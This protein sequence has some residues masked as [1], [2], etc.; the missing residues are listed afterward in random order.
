V[1]SRSHL[2]RTILSALFACIIAIS[3]SGGKAVTDNPLVPEQEHNSNNGATLEIS[4]D[5]TT[6]S[7]DY[8]YS[9]SNHYLWSYHLIYI[10]PTSPD[11]IDY[12][13][14]PV[15]NVEGHW[16]VLKFLEQGPCAN[17]IKIT[18]ASSTGNGTLNLD[19]TL[20]HPF[21]D[22]T[23][24]GFDVKG[25]LMWKGSYTFT[26]SGLSASDRYAGDGAVVDAE[27]FTS[28]YN[29]GTAG[30]GPGGLQGYFAGK[31]AVGTPDADLNGYK[32]F[33]SPGGTNTRNA[34]YAG[35][36]TTITYEVDLPDSAFVVGYA[37]DANWLPPTTI[38]VTNPIT[39]FPPE[40]NQPEPWKIETSLE[41]I[42]EGFTQ[43]GGA[44]KLIIDVY[45]WQGK[46]SHKYPEIE[47]P[48]LFDGVKFVQL[49]QDN[50]GWAR[51]EK[52]IYND[53][54]AE[55]G[56]VMLL[57]TVEDYANAGSPEYLN[58]TTYQVVDV[59]IGEHI[60]IP[61]IAKIQGTPGLY[62]CESGSFKNKGS[63][64]PDSNI[65]KYEWDWDNNGTWDEE[66]ASVFHSWPTP[67][68]NFIQFRVTTDDGQTDTLDEPFQ[69]IA[70]NSLPWS[71]PEADATTIT[72]GTT[73]HF[74][75]LKSTD[76]DCDGQ[77]ITL[78][79]WDFQGDGT[80]DA[81]GPEVEYTYNDPGFYPVDLRVRDN[82]G[83]FSPSGVPGQITVSISVI[84]YWSRVWG[85]TGVDETG[86]MVYDGSTYV[87]TAGQFSGTVDFDPTGGVM[88]LTASD[89]WD[90]YVCKYDKDGNL[91]WVVSYGGTN[92]DIAKRMEL[93]GSGDLHIVGSFLGNCDFDPG[94]GDETRISNGDYDGYHLVLDSSGGFVRVETYGDAG[95]DSVNDVAIDT[96]GNALLVGSFSDTVD[97]NP[98]VATFELISGGSTDAFLA[99]L[100]S[101]GGFVIAKSWGSTGADTA[102]GLEYDGVATIYI[103]GNFEGIV[104]FD[105]DAGTVI[106]SSNGGTDAFM[107]S[108]DLS[109]NW[110]WS[111]AWGGT[112]D[113]TGVE[114][115]LSPNG[116][117]YAAGTF[118]GT[119]N[120][121]YTGDVDEYTSNGDKDGYLIRLAD[122]GN[123][124]RTR[125]WGGTGVE[126][127]YDVTA[128]DNG[129]VYISGSFEGTVDFDGGP[130]VLE[131]TA[132]GGADACFVG[133][134]AN[135]GFRSA[136]R[137]GGTG[138]DWGTGV[139]L[140]EDGAYYLNLT[141]SDTVDMYP[142]ETLDEY[143]SNGFD[144]CALIKLSA[145]A[146]FQ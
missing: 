25:I 75:G 81:N 2:A 126:T 19:L 83:E 64:D 49:T 74:N 143:S 80:Y 120:F 68:T 16:N 32:I 119:V 43:I 50:D 8:T 46:D 31:K 12:E 41:D 118:E 37:V 44:E 10:D 96:D 101:S 128:Q 7:N 123:Y 141:W 93:D 36:N 135:G 88:E 11:G 89:G 66:G 40:A 14:V 48:D 87:Y 108:F 104:N 62:V 103:T 124:N 122:D 24:T 127:V 55:T 138:D 9:G 27:G 53:K 20:T 38:P 60:N 125:T 5:L 29:P 56:H 117:P 61:P 45:D 144:D 63:V 91:I 1:Q 30:S 107:S 116:Q 84:D 17:C 4:Q 34:L 115:T 52:I 47:C 35:G 65:I 13:M 94:A 71:E 59:E 15:R 77:S 85:G 21:A 99:I 69:V 111:Q 131:Q 114:V 22:P 90:C 95:A 100:D 42:D 132:A 86:P 112:G 140:D 33:R 110:L 102:N 113:D 92:D 136:N 73:V 23:F 109:G 145:F 67:G 18:G 82:E 39:Q 137:W 129:R 106:Q 134:N 54:L 78:Y 130:G 72:P 57:V 3:C 121:D 6:N 28:L 146:Q 70:A 98:G 139:V 133:F 58:L 79:Q 142:G 105:P 76:T 51:Y 26:N 97:F